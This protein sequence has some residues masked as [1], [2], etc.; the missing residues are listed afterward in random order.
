MHGSTR[1]SE[2]STLPAFG[3]QG[4]EWLAATP[5]FAKVEER[6]AGKDV[7]RVFRSRV[8]LHS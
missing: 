5:H 2:E 8:H 3:D 6:E 1:L 4:I 7:I